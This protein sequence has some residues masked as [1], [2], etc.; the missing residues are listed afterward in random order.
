MSAVIPH[1]KQG[2]AN[3]QVSALIYGGQL[4]QPTTTTPGTTD[5]TALGLTGCFSSFMAETRSAPEVGAQLKD[6]LLGRF[7]SC[8]SSLTT[9]PKDGNGN[10]IPAGGLSIG[11]G[12]GMGLVLGGHLRRPG[13][14]CH[15]Q[16]DCRPGGHRYRLLRAVRGRRNRC[17]RALHAPRRRISRNA[18]PAD[19]RAG[20]GRLLPGPCPDLLRGSE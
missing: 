20:L 17:R 14:H 10:P 16:R 1:Y 7:E 3:K 12:M 8:G 5:L 4:V 9:T 18:H 11:T 2:P 6:F 13:D 15:G 19:R